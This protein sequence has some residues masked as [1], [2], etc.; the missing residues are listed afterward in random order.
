[1]KVAGLVHANHRVHLYPVHKS[2]FADDPHTLLEDLSDPE[3][4]PHPEAGIRT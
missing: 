1:V 3:D 2:F 4:Y